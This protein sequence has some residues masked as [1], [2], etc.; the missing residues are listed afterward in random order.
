M[1][2]PTTLNL[3]C[4]IL[5]GRDSFLQTLRQRFATA[6]AGQGQIIQISG[7]AGIGKTRLLREFY[8]QIESAAPRILQ[9]T[10][11]ETDQNLPYAPI[12]ELLQTYVGSL[13]PEQQQAA[14]EQAGLDLIRLL[15]EFAARFSELPNADDAD[16]AKRRLHQAITKLLGQL[17]QPQ[18]LII[19]IEDLHWCD[20]TSLEFLLFLA[21][22]LKEQ[23]ILLVLTYR[24]DEISAKFA[25]WLAQL[26]RERLDVELHLPRLASEPV[27]AM[28][29]T[30]FTENFPA[31]GQFAVAVFTLSEGN[32]FYVEELLKSLVTAGDLYLTDGQWKVKPLFEVHLPRT[33]QIN[34]S[35]RLN[36]L[37]PAARNSLAMAAVAGKRFDFGL[38]QYLS[39]LSEDELLQVMRELRD[40][41]FV[42]E[43][44]A[45]RFTFRHALTRQAVYNDLL[46]RERRK[47]HR[48]MGEALEH[49]YHDD[50][51][52]LGEIAYH[53]YQ[54]EQ[55]EE[56]YGYSRQ[57]AEWAQK[58]YSPQAAVEH[59]TRA[60]TALERLGQP[61]NVE[62]LL[63][64]G[65]MYERSGNFEAARDDYTHLIAVSQQTGDQQAEWQ[66]WLD[67]GWL[68][69]ERDFARA[70]DYFPHALELARHMPAVPLLAQ[71]LNR[72]GNWHL[73]ADQLDQGLQYHQ[74]ALAIS[75]QLDDWRGQAEALDL[76]GLTSFYTGEMTAGT[77]YYARCTELLRQHADL[78]GLSS[79]L[80][81]MAMRGASYNLDTYAGPAVPIATVISE[82][83]EAVDAARKLGWRAGEASALLYAGFALGP[84]GE[85]VRALRSTHL[86]L[87]IAIEIEHLQWQG[88]AHLVLGAIYRDMLN[89]PEARRH[90]E[91]V[92][93]IAESLHAPFLSRMVIGHLASTYVAC[94]ESILAEQALQRVFTS[95]LPMVSIGQRLVW[96]AKAELALLN[97][98]PDQALDILQRLQQNMGDA[99]VPRLAYLQAEAHRLSGQHAAAETCLRKA[100]A[101]AD[102]QG[103]LPLRWRIH[104]ALGQCY[105]AQKQLEAADEA[106][107]DAA[108]VLGLLADRLIDTTLRDAYIQHT[109]VQLQRYYRPSIRRTAKRAFD[110]LT[111]REREIAALIADGK[112]NR[113]IAETLIL[114]ERTIAKHVEN[115]LAK[116]GFTSRA[117]IAAWAVERGL[118]GSQR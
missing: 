18:P 21:R 50:P 112:S 70:N 1:L 88:A 110:G 7:E 43:E 104:L 103:M 16:Q 94:G 111:S 34:L 41:Q 102:Q 90:H 101:A 58:L 52:Q 47:L 117:Q 6:Q 31:R 13:S 20:D 4:P 80:S 19:S 40:A 100:L 24:D 54:A 93:K 105:R 109:T 69:T 78:S 12:A 107:A 11:F 64:R 45:D 37:S 81:V 65:K 23:P 85:Y 51:N 42:M 75:E 115:T 73:H 114:S 63:A 26:V 96:C 83:D 56:A 17:C 33:I 72:V 25:R 35:Q 60:L 38:L 2:H 74:Q 62:L 10:C 76:L 44:S 67:L 27:G 116:L 108:D 91:T 86:G 92:F 89:L 55:W 113:A 53:F 36:Q 22:Q 28:V 59:Y 106:F 49:L 8:A 97:D 9:G 95:D 3:T 87:E 32:P 118:R 68:W 77:D 30:I 61:P 15:P 5:I 39:E 82:S 57:A 48:A 66:G 29:R 79:S 71:T 84:R 99:V 14:I 46:L 98:Q